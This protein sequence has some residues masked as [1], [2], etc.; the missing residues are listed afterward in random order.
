MTPSELRVRLQIPRQFNC[1]AR[2]NLIKSIMLFLL[3]IG[4]VKAPISHLVL[5]RS[6]LGAGLHGHPSQ[7]NAKVS[8]CLCF[9]WKM[10]AFDDRGNSLCLERQLPLPLSVSV[11]SGVSSPFLSWQEAVLSLIC[12]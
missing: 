3:V 2:V 1:P 11:A 8:P 6:L 12:S 9:S 7:L 5:L 10:H 4:L